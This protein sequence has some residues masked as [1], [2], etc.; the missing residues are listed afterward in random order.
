MPLTKQQ[1]LAKRR[2]I[3]ELDIGGGETFTVQI[4]PVMLTDFLQ[5]KEDLP[6]VY[7]MIVGTIERRGESSSYINDADENPVAKTLSGLDFMVAVALAGVVEP[8]L[9][10]NP[11]L[12]ELSP[13]DLE[14]FG[15]GEGQG[16]PNLQRLSEEILR[17]SDLNI[18]FRGAGRPASEATSAAPDSTNP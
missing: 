1:L 5:Y 18:A 4:K 2:V 16:M 7:R 3:V 17:I 12:G 11:P 14:P 15:F 13:F 10:L 8:K 9:Y 6:A